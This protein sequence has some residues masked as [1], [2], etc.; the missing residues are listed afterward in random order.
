MLLPL[1]KHPV[2]PKGVDGS[3]LPSEI[4]VAVIG[5]RQF[6]RAEI[7]FIWFGP[8]PDKKFFERLKAASIHRARIEIVALFGC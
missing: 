3:P 5:A 2:K 4:I 6:V 8:A 7:I 1:E